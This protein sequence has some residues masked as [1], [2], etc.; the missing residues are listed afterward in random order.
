MLMPH[1]STV[2]DMDPVGVDLATDSVMA[3]RS[4]LEPEEK[5]IDSSICDSP[6]RSNGFK[7]PVEEKHGRAAENGASASV[8][9]GKGDADGQAVAMETSFTEKEGVKNGHLSRFLDRQ[10]PHLRANTPKRLTHHH[11]EDDSDSDSEEID[12]EEGDDPEKGS[13]PVAVVHFLG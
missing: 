1:E 2:S 4:R 13:G 12:D 6:L 3:D 10:V 11:D 7:K 5:S 8:D 9:E